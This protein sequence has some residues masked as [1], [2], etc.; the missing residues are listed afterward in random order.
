MSHGVGVP[1]LFDEARAHHHAGRLAEAEA[2]YRQVLALDPA[3]GEGLRQL[4]QLAHQT[5]RDALAMELLGQAIAAASGWF[6]AHMAL[7]AAFRTRG[8][9]EQA[10]LHYQKAI[11]LRPD[12]PD[13]YNNLGNVLLDKG[14]LDAA[15]LAYQRAIT[16]KPD[17]AD[18]CNNLGVV[19]KERGKL[20]DA[21]LCYRCALALRPDYP[22]AH[23]NLGNILKDQ[24]AYESA[25]EHYSRALSLRPHYAEAHNN[26]GNALKEMGQLDEAIVCYQQAIALRPNYAE[27]YN[28]LG[29]VLKDRLELDEAHTL[30]QYALE[31]KPDYAEAHNNLGNV[32]KD[33][34]VLDQALE[35]Y[36]RAIALKPDYVEAHWNESLLR[37]VQGDFQVGWEKY[38]WRWRKKDFGDHGLPGS[39]WD[40][41]DLTGK[42]VLLHAEQGYG[43]SIQF[44]RYAPL[45]KAAGGTVIV[46]C[47]AALL[48]VFQAVAGVDQWIAEGTEPLPAFDCHAPLLSLPRLFATD[49]ATIPGGAPYLRVD[50]DRLAIWQERLAAWSKGGAGSLKVGVV[51]RGNPKHKNDRNRSMPASAMAPLCRVPGLQ[52]FVVQKDMTVPEAEALATGGEPIPDLG[53]YLQ[54]WAETA[55]A[56][57]ALDLVIT[58]DTAVAHLAGALGKPAWVLLPFAPDWRWLM[59]RDDSPWYPT[60]RLF[61]QP[62]IGDWEAVI[63]AVLAALP[64]RPFL[65]GTAGPI[66]S[67]HEAQPPSVTSL[68]L[69]AEKSQPAL[70]K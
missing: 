50:S 42:T 43:D 29:N 2:L 44:I 19:F 41:G 40:G 5:G 35:R 67:A 39:L 37:L 25:V 32:L 23:N 61:R 17:Y 6:E 53:P 20:D 16:L 46:R 13:A 51:W 18:G 26:L 34:G 54:D 27:A 7:G 14:D 22:E 65:T 63:A 33:W 55:A 21:A 28:N 68:P 62:R 38:E 10:I 48:R 11:S 45:V 49:A 24:G 4:I 60:L 15:A 69:F 1:E 8:E 56:V 12:A 31:L 47:P 3:H 58:V 36:L 66:P 52:P 30:Y 57:S 9:G 64:A 70:S 59:A